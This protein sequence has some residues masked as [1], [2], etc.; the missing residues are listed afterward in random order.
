MLGVSHHSIRMNC[1]M[2]GTIL[3]ISFL[4]EIK[5]IFFLG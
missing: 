1:I 2:I 3:E 5:M 4:A